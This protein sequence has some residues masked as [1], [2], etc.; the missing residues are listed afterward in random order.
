MAISNV[1]MSGSSLVR[2][3]LSRRQPLSFQELS[4]PQPGNLTGD[5]LKL[6]RACSQLF[7]E[8]LL[9]LPDGKEC[10][11]RMLAQLPEH[12]NWQTAFLAAFQSH[13]EQ[14]VD[15]EK[16]WG[17]TAVSFSRTDATPSWN[18]SEVWKKMQAALE[19][20]VSVH[21]NSAQMPVEARYTLQE[22]IAKWPDA[23]VGPAVERAIAGLESLPTQSDKGFS[24]MAALYLQTLQGYLMGCRDAAHPLPLG[25]NPPSALHLLKANTV[26]QLNLLDKQRDSLQPKAPPRKAPSVA[27]NRVASAGK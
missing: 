6:Y 17:L 22:V 15:V 26:Q 9:Q 21:L 5:G 20:P 24:L 8:G 23:D 13:F 16:W 7:L 14:L 3:E 25:R 1:R 10:L 18:E 11:L 19:V 4:W 27:Q 12:L 2:D